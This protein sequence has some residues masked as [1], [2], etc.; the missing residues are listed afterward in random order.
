MKSTES[1][2]RDLEDKLCDKIVLNWE[3]DDRFK[4][5]KEMQKYN[6]GIAD[7]MSLIRN[8]LESDDFKSQPSGDSG[9]KIAC[10]EII[11]NIR[12]REI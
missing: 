2:L 12:L 6:C 1:Y 3:Q 5:L 11:S 9:D 4:S 8:T 7:A 10:G